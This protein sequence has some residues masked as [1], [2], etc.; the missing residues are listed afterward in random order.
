[1]AGEERP[2][3]GGRKRNAARPEAGGSA[4]EAEGAMC[5]MLCYAICAVCICTVSVLYTGLVP[6]HRIPASAETMLDSYGLIGLI[7]THP[8]MP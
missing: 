8:N 4:T 7:R 1:M 3:N 2:T 5:H 6:R